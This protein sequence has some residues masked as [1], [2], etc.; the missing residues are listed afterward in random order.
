MSNFHF[1]ANLAAHV[2]YVWAVLTKEAAH[3]DCGSSFEIIQPWHPAFFA[4]LPE[5]HPKCFTRTWARSLCGQGWQKEGGKEGKC[6]GREGLKKR[7]WKPGKESGDKIFCINLNVYQVRQYKEVQRQTGWRT[8]I[9]ER[10]RN[11][12]G[13]ERTEWESICVVSAAIC[14]SEHI[15]ESVR[16]VPTPPLSPYWLLDTNTHTSPFSETRT[17]F[18]YILH[19]DTCKQTAFNPRWEFRT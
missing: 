9:L 10:R 12:S 17:L 13:C 4:H 5:S 8:S 2:R 16:P 1:K 14:V 11:E 19:S 7:K 6:E 3:S 18:G 15:T